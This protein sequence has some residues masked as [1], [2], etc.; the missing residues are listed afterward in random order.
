MLEHL[1]NGVIPQGI[2]RVVADPD[3]PGDRYSVVQFCHP[4]PWTIL[5]PVPSCIT[6]DTP[7][8]FSPIAASHLLRQVLFDINLVEDGRR[9]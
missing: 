8:R 1:T 4:T 6:P 7:Q 3:Q 9:V 2:H 5:D